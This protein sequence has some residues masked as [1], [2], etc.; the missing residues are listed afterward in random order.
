MRTFSTVELTQHIGAVTHAATREP[1]TITHHRKP[2][3]VLMSIEDFEKLREA[4]RPR[5]AYG[6]GETP[7]ELAD[8]LSSELERRISDGASDYAD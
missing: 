3:F 6:V 7:Q 2:R 1:V 4:G 8:I 5:R